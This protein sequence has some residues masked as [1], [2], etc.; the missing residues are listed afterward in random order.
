MAYQFLTNE[1]VVETF[2]TSRQWTEGLTNNFTE[3]ERIARN[4]PHPSTPKELPKTTDGTTASIIRKTPKRIIQ[5]LPTGKVISD[6]DDWL[7]VI[8]SF[9]YTNKILR[10]SNE[11]YDLIQK[12][13]MVVE[14][15][16]T[17]GFCATYT[18]FVERQGYFCSDLRL[19]YWADVF[20]QP[21]KISDE[22][23]NFIFLRSWWQT[24]DIDALIDSQSK[25]SKKTEKT[26]NVDAL[27]KIKD[28]ET[29]K[30]ERAKTPAEKEQQVDARGGI[31][32]VTGFQRGVGS[33]FYTFHVGTGKVVRTKINKDPRGD[34]PINFAY[35]DI[36]G[37]NI[38][39][40]GII[41]LVGSLQNLIDG[42]MQMYQFNR[43]LMLA[44]PVIKKGNFPKSR[45]KWVPNSIIDVGND[46]NAG[47]EPVKIDTSA[48]QNFPN[49]YGL[50][51]SQLVSLVSSPDTS[52][53]A[54]VGNPG[55][56]KTPAGV[57][58]VQT[59]LSI[60]DNYIRKQFET[61]F[62]KW[63]ETAINLY[64]AER[65]G[66][67]ELQLDKKTA[68]ELRKLAEQGKFDPNLLSDDNKVRINYSSAT[69]A[70]K[71]EV[72][73][74][75]SKMQDEVKELQS[76]QG[77]T[78]LLDK[79]QILQALIPP[80]KIMALWNA[81]V[82]NAGV[83]NPE[84][85]SMSDEETKQAIEK[86]SQPKDD[87]KE[88]LNSSYKDLPEDIKRQAEEKM[89][90]QPSQMSSPSQQAVDVQKMQAE[91]AMQPPTDQVQFSSEDQQ[92]IDALT[93]LGANQQ[94]IGQALAMLH[95]GHSPEEVMQM[96]Q[97]AGQ[98]QEKTNAR[99]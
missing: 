53:S 41:D 99:R 23:S 96:L 25:L 6:T 22:D 16:L 7:S 81:I 36:D 3:Y 59:N 5:Q 74:S 39:G 58:Q 30:E 35:G 86:A 70:L 19:P 11:G 90:F 44:P 92:L 82:K 14:K 85:V 77:L 38:F 20:G 24:K 47:I 43:A 83:E 68:D 75:T 45:V 18:P 61:W 64:F 12:C 34:I 94:Q 29:T 76:L 93:Q 28:Y 63:S 27:R 37:S 73:A 79:T 88:Y 4:R 71:F 95:A 87:T 91:T 66:V 98:P 52:I 55:F 89:G 57:K 51:K 2:K 62:A 60:D 49:N 21:G 32:L 40:R 10:N 78:Q 33:K 54:E 69:P 46:G 13:W 56:S 84:K 15:F 9:V 42:E 26:W 50:M 1:N 97:N 17:F 31:E 72:D 67:E 8:A 80:E 48:H 65:S